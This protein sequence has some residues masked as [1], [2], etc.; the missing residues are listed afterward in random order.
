MTVLRNG[1]TSFGLAIGVSR[2]ESLDDVA[3]FAREIE[4]LGF[5]SLWMQDNPLTTKDPYMALAIVAGRTSRLRL[6]PGVSSA[7]LRHPAIIAN[8]IKTLESEAPG[9]TF[10]GLGSGGP[11]LLSPLGLPSRRMR[12][13]RQE[14]R[15]LRD[16]LAGRGVGDHAY[17]VRYPEERPI[18]V[19]VAASGEMMLAASGE[20]ADGV[21]LAGPIVKPR[22]VD[23]KDRF[24]AA[25][26]ASGRDSSGLEVRL[27]TNMF[28]DTA[29]GRGLDMVRPF[30][31]SWIHADQLRAGREVSDDFAAVIETVKELHDPQRHLARGAD[32]EAVPDDL[33]RQVAIVGSEEECRAR[34]RDI[35]E[36]SPVEIVFTVPARNRMVT[37]Q[38][39]ASVVAGL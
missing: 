32:S 11:S 1:V 14:L 28:V 35:L 13:F 3:V 27:L 30:V 34:I 29:N 21:L 5:N 18:P 7:A 15:D 39:M 25:A 2:R 8:G 10:L 38:A 36:L 23:H 22:L 19:L 26:E 31:A 4:E 33:A 6:G 24:L 9:R 17:M 12:A 20:L 16:L 37:V